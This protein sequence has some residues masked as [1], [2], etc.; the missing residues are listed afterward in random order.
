V[1]GGVYHSGRV[2]RRGQRLA[3]LLVVAAAFAAP[4]GAATPPDVSARAYVV[5]SAVDGT[6][7]AARAGDEPRAIASITKLMTVLVA[8]QRVSLDDRV[9]VA[10]AAARIGESS[11]DLRAGE[12]LLVRDLATAALVA[13]AND[14]ATAL[15][16][17]ATGSEER[18][19]ELM[20]QQAAK[21]GMD[22]THFTNPH[23]LDEPG[24][25]SSAH[26]TVTLLRA[27]LRNPFVAE[28]AGRRAATLSD[29]RRLTS[30]NDLLSRMPAMVAGKTG[31]TDDA[32]WSEV[33]AARAG[34]A[35][36]FTSVLGSASEE[37]RN[38]D[39]QALLRWGL[40][41]YRPSRVVDPARVY[42]TAEAGWGL[43]DV[44]LVARAPAVRPAP[45]DR[46]LVE[47]VVAPAVVALPVAAGD[48]LGELRVYDG[49]RL[50]VRSPLVA[51]RSVDEPGLLGKVGYIA[52]RAVHHLAGLVS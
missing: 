12:R 1:V 31:H 19:V 40:A 34:G 26:D 38:A 39:L 50:V 7:L 30:T 13:S 49:T 46:P 10:P 52:R 8:L 37:K 2:I 44:G 25:S 11:I 5:A 48:V 24:Q 15:A 41:Q 3:C 35:T 28:W 9:V 17:Y 42:A 51:D 16:L 4:A 33:A 32:G 6:T 21:L 45:V 22:A 29:G 20:N 18:F 36:I 27:A 23:G 43:R 14:A 47:R